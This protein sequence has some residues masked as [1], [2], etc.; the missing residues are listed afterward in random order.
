MRFKKFLVSLIVY[1]IRTI[2]MLLTAFD[3]AARDERS[4]SNTLTYPIVQET[5]HTG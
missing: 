3:G 2:S 4:R 5:V 1:P